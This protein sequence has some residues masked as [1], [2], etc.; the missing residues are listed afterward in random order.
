MSRNT[1]TGA[2]ARFSIN[3]TKIGFATNVNVNEEIEYQPEDVLDNIQSEDN[4]PVAYR[5]SM[6]ASTIKIVGTTIKALGLFPS[7]GTSP[8]EHLR[9]ILT[10]K[11]LVCTL[12]DNQTNVA[13]ATIEQVKVSAQNLRVDARGIS[14]TDLTFVAIRVRD[15]SE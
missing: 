14:G 10:Q 1:F 12:E 4:V 5:V 8:L 9:N 7:L 3:G 2:R 6:T 15:E 11:D 13:V